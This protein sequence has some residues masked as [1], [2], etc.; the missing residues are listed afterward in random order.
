MEKQYEELYWFASS[1]QYEPTKILLE[2]IEKK[3]A[4]D[5]E[6]PKDK[7]E[8]YLRVIREMNYT[9]GKTSPRWPQEIERMVDNLRSVLQEFETTLIAVGKGSSFFCGSSTS[10]KQL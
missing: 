1:T 10:P 7:K 8:N 4:D 2:S 9:M 3:L 5:K 6:I